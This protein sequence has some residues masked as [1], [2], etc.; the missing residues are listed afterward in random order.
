MADKK[1]LP[2]LIT[3]GI[4]T[5]ISR[6]EFGKGL[7]G[8]AT[9]IAT[10]PLLDSGL[11][12]VG[13]ISKGSSIL[14]KIPMTKELIKRYYKIES[15][16]EKFLNKLAKEEKFQIGGLTEN[17]YYGTVEDQYEHIKKLT[18]LK[19]RLTEYSK[20]TDSNKMPITY[21][22]R[23]DK[24]GNE[25][26]DFRVPGGDY[27]I[28]KDKLKEDLDYVTRRLK[29]T[30]DMLNNNENKVQKKAILEL[31]KL[32]NEQNEIR[33]IASNKKLPFNFAIEQVQKEEYDF[34]D[35]AAF[36]SGQISDSDQSDAE[37]LNEAREEYLIDDAFENIKKFEDLE[38]EYNIINSIEEKERIKQDILNDTFIQSRQKYNR[39]SID[40]THG[41]ITQ[42]I[43]DPNL[44][45]KMK[46][47]LA[48]LGAEQYITNE[49]N[50]IKS[51]LESNTYTVYDSGLSGTY[52][53]SYGEKEIDPTYSKNI[54]N[55]VKE[56]ILSAGK[57]IA[58]D[59]VKDKF[60]TREGK[61][62][63]FTKKIADIL[64]QFKT[65][66]SSSTSIESDKVRAEKAKEVKEVK[67]QPKQDI[68]Q[69][70]KAKEKPIRNLG[71]DL[72]GI[73]KRLKY[74]PLG[75]AFYTKEVGDA[76]LPLE[77]SPRGYG[78]RRENKGRS[79]RDYYKSYN[80]QR[81]I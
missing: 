34:I 29:N 64:K 4:G 33:T 31:L 48:E 60:I 79:S 27:V 25:I 47:D 55:T 45:A 32:D 80:T 17:T 70:P 52:G 42:S 8:I 78:M 76:E 7:T 3:K 81:L 38:N 28:K 54:L 15:L 58:K 5:D 2:D 22:H 44:S 46:E 14:K 72:L 50:R 63:N 19:N 68:K 66:K 30:L 57:D 61:P 23:V 18:E 67:Q 39:R 65:V 53:D 1:G 71:Q 6:R 43:R 13:N 41:A 51:L 40:G 16:K 69:Q 35:D 36:G 26:T 77:T 21:T 12:A 11:S 62:G 49:K 74:S 73:G 37:F 24:Q 10:G 56:E 75:A 59:Y 20:I 9:E